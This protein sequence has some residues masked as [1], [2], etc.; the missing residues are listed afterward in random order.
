MYDTPV[1]LLCAIAVSDCSVQLFERA[2]CDWLTML[3]GLLSALLPHWRL[4]IDAR[5]LAPLATLMRAP[6]PPPPP[7]PSLPPSSP[8]CQRVQWHELTRWTKSGPMYLFLVPMYLFLAPLLGFFTG[9]FSWH[10]RIYLLAP[11]HAI[12]C[13]IW[14]SPIVVSNRGLH[15]GPQTEGGAEGFFSCGAPN[16]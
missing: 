9:V 3:L 7:P 1:R 16:N 10:H 12:P 2:T 14:W 13:H 8:P 5:T 6:E 15:R 11:F 4:H